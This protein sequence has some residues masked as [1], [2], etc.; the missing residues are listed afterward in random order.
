LKAL[1]IRRIAAVMSVVPE[2]E[3]GGVMLYLI[4]TLKLGL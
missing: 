1:P 2:A 3:S 4:G